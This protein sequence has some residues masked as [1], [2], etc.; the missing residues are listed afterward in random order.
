LRRAEIAVFDAGVNELAVAIHAAIDLA[1]DLD[2]SSPQ[3]ARL[4]AAL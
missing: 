1:I 4:F 3:R 2:E